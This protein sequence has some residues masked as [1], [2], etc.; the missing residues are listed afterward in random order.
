VGLPVLRPSG[1][2]LPLHH[3]VLVKGQAD[4]VHVRAMEEVP[5][6]LDDIVLELTE[7]DENWLTA[8]PVNLGETGQPGNC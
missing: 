7:A 8:E 6:H 2:L 5:I 3:K 1:R 4:A